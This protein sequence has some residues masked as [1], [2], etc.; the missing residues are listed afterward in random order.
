MVTTGQSILASEYNSLRSSVSAI[1][2]TSYGQTL[3]SSVVTNTGS[4]SLSTN[5]ISAT[6]MQ[7]L[8]LDIQRTFVHQTGAVST[9]IAVPI[10]GY[11]IAADTS[12]SVNTT[13]G[14]KT[15]VVDG[16]KMGFNDYNTVVIAISNFDGSVSGWPAGNFTLGTAITSSRTTSWGGSSDAVQS[17]YHVLTITFVDANQMNYY[18]NA[19]G[20]IRLSASL[21]GPSSAKDTDWQGLLSSMGTIIFNK[22]RITASSGTPTPSGSGGSGFD[23]LTSSYRQLFIKSGSGVYAN[24]EYTIEGRLSA[25]NEIRFRISMNDDYVGPF[26]DQ[27]VTGTITSTVNTNR[28]DSSFVYNATTY[29]AVDIVAPTLATQ[30]ALSTNN[31]SIPA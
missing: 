4:P 18:F 3:I 1:L 24:N 21:T 25:T 16:T 5:K 30:V 31:L 28:P 12:Q 15:S 14:A 22:Y 19:G 10:T 13:T 8:F 7:D 26:V 27:S 11:N 17:I 23:S 20:Q 29:D 2:A 6:Q 9:T